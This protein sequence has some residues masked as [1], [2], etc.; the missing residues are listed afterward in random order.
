M[1]APKSNSCSATARLCAATKAQGAGE[2][3]LIGRDFI[4]KDRIELVLG[5]NSFFGNALPAVLRRVA[6][7][8]TGATVFS[9]QVRDPERYGVVTFD[10]ADRAISIVE[11]PE[12]PASR[13]A[14]TGLYFF[15]NEVAHH[16]AQIKPSRRGEMEITDVNMRYLEAGAL[17]VE[18]LGRGLPGSIPAPSKHSST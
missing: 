6:S 16:A 2:A 11:K 4:A 9:Y 17:Q 13:W 7:R 12:N 8:E 18:K 5:D 10:D 1:I 3:F 15:A 14:I